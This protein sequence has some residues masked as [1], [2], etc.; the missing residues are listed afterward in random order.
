MSSAVTEE[1]GRATSTD[2]EQ[3]QKQ[4]EPEQHQQVP[5]QRQRELSPAGEAESGGT[6]GAAG[7]PVNGLDAIVAD[8]N[9]IRELFNRYDTAATAQAK[10]TAARNLVR[11]V[12]RHASAEERTLY[13]L[14][15]EKHP[16]ANLAKMLY[17]RMINK[18]VLEFLESHVPAGDAEWVLYDA[19]LAK[20]R[21]IEDE[22]MAKEEAEVIEPLRQ[23]LDASAVAKLG[24]RW[25]AAFANAPTHPH[26]GGTSGAARAR[27]V[28]PVVGLIDRMRDALAT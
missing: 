5:E 17:D 25:S 27:L 28:H 7:A 16:Q 23:V 22:H 1:T 12:S 3:L 24:R 19:T 18:E 4:Q 10:V 14:L 21:M 20:F 13:P 8:H 15:R 26:P 2:Q 11:H 9:V 6:T